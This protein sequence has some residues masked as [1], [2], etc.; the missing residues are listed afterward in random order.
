MKK[1]II[2][3]TSVLVVIAGI[4]VGIVLFNKNKNNRTQ[5]RT[6]ALKKGDIEA[7]V[8]ASGTLNPITIVEVG[9]QVSGRIA[10]LY[11]DFNSKV[12][13]GQVIAE[14]DQ[15]LL[16][17]KVQQNEANYQ[18]AIASLEKAKVTLDN[19]KKKYDRSLY[20]FEKNLVSY[21]EKE[22]AEA[23]FFGAKTDVQSAEARVEQAKSQLDS[24]QV[25]LAYAT[26]RSPIDG[27]V[28]S[29]TV[30]V[31]QT[32]A[33]SFQAP[34]LFKIANDLSKMR[35]ECGVDE[36]DIGK[37]KEGQKVRFTVDAFP[38]DT[39]AGKV[40]QVRYSPDVVQNVV[41]YITIIDVENL[42]MKLR[43]GMT[44]TVSIITGEARGVLKVPNSS[45]RFTPP[46]SAEEMQE[47]MK[48]AGQAM[49]E[50]RQA[51][52]QTEG[53]T[54]RI[55]SQR[56]EGGRQASGFS[57]FQGEGQF[58]GQGRRMQTAQVWIEDK[59]GKPF[60]V[61]IKPGVTDNTYTEVVW[62]D[63]KEGQLVITGLQARKQS[64][65]PTGPPPGG[66]MFIRR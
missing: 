59:N 64:S 7:L 15:S 5:Y 29:R 65:S 66:M 44:A 8:I 63:L 41:T 37:V 49:M 28:I 17:A 10:K 6:E 45:L 47:I 32:V 1:R 18:T 30:N 42:E 11:A 13:E 22:A 36:A 50:K 35:V 60:P 56:T 2:F 54:P 27:I 31:G 24:S 38:Q 12:K 58:R 14:L 16:E 4:I 3:T 46:L 55:F 23:Q 21:E 53:S 61:F 25:D 39:F 43:P 26:I 40:T 52:G 34:V 57:M 62:G 33:A 48:K 51:Q 19:A 9:S 20:L